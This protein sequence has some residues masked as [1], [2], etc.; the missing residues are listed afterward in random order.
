MKNRRYLSLAVIIFGLWSC[1]PDT[2]TLPVEIC[3]TSLEITIGGS[4]TV[5]IPLEEDGATSIR[6]Q[7]S[8]DY[9]KAY[10]A[11]CEFLDNSTYGYADALNEGYQITPANGVWE[12]KDALLSSNISTSGKFKD[13]GI[14]FLGF[15]IPQADG[16]YFYG[17]FRLECYEGGK[18]LHLID[19]AINR[20]V[21]EPIITGATGTGMNCPAHPT[22]EIESVDEIIGNYRA[23][24]D[25]ANLCS[26]SIVVSDKPGYDFIIRN[27][28]FTWPFPEVYGKVVNGWLELPYFSY[29]GNIPTP[30]G[31]PRTY[32]ANFSGNGAMQMPD[33]EV[34]L[35]L[36]ISYDQTGFSPQS[37]HGPFTMIKC[38]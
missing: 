23:Q 28:P 35:D 32:Q 29:S 31:N 27:F 16:G 33:Q 22:G 15:R 17:W 36:Q 8:S 4:S 24:S 19:Y 12:P 34:V 7:L 25:T 14:R 26:I 38:D 10:A 5:T 20:S 11:N 1:D 21:D 3:H 9:V 18:M 30:G 37:F 6:F 13:A 2:T